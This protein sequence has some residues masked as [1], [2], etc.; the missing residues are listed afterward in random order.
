[1]PLLNSNL[2][3]MGLADLVSEFVPSLIDELSLSSLLVNGIL[4]A[5]GAWYLPSAFWVCFLFVILGLGALSPEHTEPEFS[6]KL[7]R[8]GLPQA[9]IVAP[10]LA[11][12]QR[13]I[14]YIHIGMLGISH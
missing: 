10:L 4:Y 12:G 14:P 7:K 8:F 6:E 3:Q 9:I 1:M 13:R 5:F 11:C 2:S